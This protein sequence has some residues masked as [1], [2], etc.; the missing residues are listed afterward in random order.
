MHAA[1]ELNTGKTIVLRF[2]SLD[3]LEFAAVLVGGHGPFCWGPSA[4]DAAHTAV[5]LEAIA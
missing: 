2:A 1:Y 4:H 3:P 5:V